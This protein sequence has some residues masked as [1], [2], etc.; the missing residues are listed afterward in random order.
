LPTPQ[1]TKEAK[2]KRLVSKTNRWEDH[3]ARRAKKEHFPARSVYKLQEIQ[4]R[5][6]LI[7]KGDKVLDLGCF[8]GSWLLYIADLIGPK[9]EVIGIDP[10]PVS[11]KLPSNTQIYSADVLALDD[12]LRESIGRNFNVLLSDMAPE[13][14]GNK[15]VDAARSLELCQAALFY[16]QNLLIRNGSF[17]CKI[18]QGADFKQFTDSVGT[19]FNQHKIFKPQS[20]RKASKEIYIIGIGKK[21][22]VNVRSQQM[23]EHKT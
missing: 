5:Y 20:T 3:Y 8:P 2:L 6:K 10:K 23:V 9:G 21:G 4:H 13:T 17:V 16:A 22:G 7:K 19:T 1:I 15:H 18:F 12:E 11:I 14:T